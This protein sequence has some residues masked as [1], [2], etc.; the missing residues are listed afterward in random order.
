MLTLADYNKN[1]YRS[2]IEENFCH[3]ENLNK[4]SCPQC[5]RELYDADNIEL[6]GQ[7]PFNISQ[8]TVVCKCGFIG[9]RFDT[10]I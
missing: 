5:E 4:L 3:E 6:P 7:N 9:T 1:I 2:Y 10:G 8:I